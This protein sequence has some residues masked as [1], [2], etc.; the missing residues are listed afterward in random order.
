APAV[1]HGKS[2]QSTDQ[3]TGALAQND[4]RRSASIY[5][6]RMS[7]NVSCRSRG[8][9]AGKTAIGI[10]KGRQRDVLR[11]SPFGDPN[12]SAL[13]AQRIGRSDATLKS[14]FCR[15]PTQATVAVIT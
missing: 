3:I 11:V 5:H 13:L 7:G 1:L 10:H 15:S 14:L 9:I 4:G 2:I 8:F 12:F 6:C